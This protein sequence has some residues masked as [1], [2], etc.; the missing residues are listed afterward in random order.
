MGLKIDIQNQVKNIE[1]ETFT[2]EQ[3]TTV[4]TISNGKLTFGC[5]GLEFEATVLYIDMRGSTS[6]LN[7]HKKRVVA[8]YTCFIIMR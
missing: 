2:V 4:P 7:T 1:S 8:K 5:K 6:V 3:T